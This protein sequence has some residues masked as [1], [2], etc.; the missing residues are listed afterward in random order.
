MDFIRMLDPRYQARYQHYLG[1]LR[2]GIP[3]KTPQN[4]RR[5]SPA[6]SKPAVFEIKVDKYRLYLVRSGSRWYATH[7][8]EK[9]KDNQVNRESDKALTIFWE[10][11][12]ERQ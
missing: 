9:P 8:R 3:I 6:G 1:Y 4:F 5:V 10:S 2:D 11:N 7:G 12:G